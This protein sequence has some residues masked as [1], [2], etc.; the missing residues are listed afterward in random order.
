M[1]EGAP[2]QWLRALLREELHHVVEVREFTDGF[3]GVGI[4]DCCLCFG[5]RLKS[6]DLA[7]KK[8]CRLAERFESDAFRDYA[9]ELCE[10][11]Y[12][13]LP[14][15]CLLVLRSHWGFLVSALE[16]PSRRT[17]LSSPPR[18]YLASLGR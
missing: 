16:P 15:A 12:C 11:L 2:V 4:D 5:D 14:A 17:V 7:V 8:A 1:H 13:I 9:V 10:R 6:G 18:L 3:F